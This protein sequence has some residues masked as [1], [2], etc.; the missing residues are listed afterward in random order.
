MGK[1]KLKGMTI[2]EA[3]DF[4]DEHDIFEFRDVK[5]VRD[6][7][8]NLRKKKYMGVDTDLYKKI[9]NKAKRLNTQEEALIKEWLEEKV[10]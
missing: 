1:S 4:F 6:I 10:A 9:R 2:G 3:S 8:F 7:K 5:E